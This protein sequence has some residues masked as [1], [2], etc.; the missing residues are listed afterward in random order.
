MTNRIRNKYAI[1]GEYKR[2]I[3]T[4]GHSIFWIRCY[5]CWELFTLWCT[6]IQDPASATTVTAIRV[7]CVQHQFYISRQIVRCFLKKLKLVLDVFRSSLFLY[8]LL[9]IGAKRPISSFMGWLWVQRAGGWRVERGIGTSSNYC[10]T[11]LQ[12]HHPPSPPSS[13]TQRLFHFP[14]QYIKGIVHLKILF[15]SNHIFWVEISGETL[16]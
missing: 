16:L 3:A 7:S 12:P 5:L 2:N 4:S 8:F 13:P 1:K 10:R 11:L 15:P 6:V 9:F 14:C